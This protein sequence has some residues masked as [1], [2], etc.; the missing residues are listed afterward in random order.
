M[1]RHYHRTNVPP[2]GMIVWWVFLGI[3]AVC[4]SIYYAIVNGPKKK[5]QEQWDREYFN[6]WRLEQ[7]YPTSDDVAHGLFFDKLDKITCTVKGYPG[8]PAC[9]VQQY[10]VDGRPQA[11]PTEPAESSR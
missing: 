2:R 6:G 4:F 8:Y 7:S 5:A 11:A 3:C 10:F 1:S 9:P